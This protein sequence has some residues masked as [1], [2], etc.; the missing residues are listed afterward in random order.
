MTCLC[1]HLPTTA[2]RRRAVPLFHQAQWESSRE[3]WHRYTNSI[4]STLLAAALKH[5][6]KIMPYVPRPS[7]GTNKTLINFPHFY[8]ERTDI[9]LIVSWRLQYNYCYQTQTPTQLFY[10]FKPVIK[11]VKRWRWKVRHL[12][13]LRVQSNIHLL[14]VGFTLQPHEPVALLL[15]PVQFLHN[16]SARLFFSIVIVIRDCNILW[17]IKISFC[18]R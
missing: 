17:E 1:A 12:T 3:T 4:R 13:S 18:N 15:C 2:R 8:K 16:R 11:F 6:S 14:L 9:A 10:T 5:I 7:S